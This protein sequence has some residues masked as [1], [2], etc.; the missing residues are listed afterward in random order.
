MRKIGKYN[1]CHPY[2]MSRAVTGYWNGNWWKFQDIPD[3]EFE[4]D[5]LQW[6]G[7]LIE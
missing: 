1:V 5:D 2:S 7:N 6:I 4:D 3:G